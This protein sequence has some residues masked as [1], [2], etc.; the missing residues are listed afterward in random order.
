MITDNDR[1]RFQSYFDTCLQLMRGR[2]YQRAG[3]LGEEYPGEFKCAYHDE[4]GQACHIG[5][6]LPEEI[7]PSLANTDCNVLHLHMH[8]QWQL[9]PKQLA[10]DI[11]NKKAFFNRLQEIHDD[12]DDDEDDYEG[13]MRRFAEHFD[14]SYEAP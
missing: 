11:Q 4:H 5:A 6:L 3:Q 7:R 14:L 13:M 10:N 1:P 9:F 2:N 8:A 12:C